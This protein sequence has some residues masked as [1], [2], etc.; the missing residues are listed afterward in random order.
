MGQCSVALG[1]EHDPCAR[2]LELAFDP[3]IAITPV[4]RY[5]QL[6]ETRRSPAPQ[7][8]SSL[9]L[10][11]RVDEGQGVSGSTTKAA[12]SSPASFVPAI[13]MA[14]LPLS[15]NEGSRTRPL[16]RRDPDLALEWITQF[17]P[18]WRTRTTRRAGPARSGEPCSAWSTRL[19]P[20]TKPH[21]SNEP[22]EASTTSSS[23]LARR[24]RVQ[25]VPERQGFLPPRPGPGLPLGVPPTP[26]RWPSEAHQPQS[27]RKQAVFLRDPGRGALAETWC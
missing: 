13:P 7:V 4:G 20:G 21:V 6:H 8:R 15:G 16:R 10:L 27:A 11:A 14:T 22:T 23:E 1:R 5:W 26:Q 19:P 3:A 17:G 2:V 24:V 12:R 25:V 18:T 9:S